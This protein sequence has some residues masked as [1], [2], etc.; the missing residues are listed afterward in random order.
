MDSLKTWNRKEVHLKT[1]ALMKTFMCTEYNNLDEVDGLTI[2]SSNLNQ[3][4]IL[5]ELKDH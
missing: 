4:N 3:A 1:Y 2:A 5:Q